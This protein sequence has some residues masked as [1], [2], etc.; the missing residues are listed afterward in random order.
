MSTPAFLWYATKRICRSFKNL[1]RKFRDYLVSL[2]KDWEYESKVY[3]ACNDPVSYYSHDYF[4][5]E[6]GGAEC[7]DS[8][9]FPLKFH[10]AASLFSNLQG[11]RILDYGS[12]R[13]ELTALLTSQGANVLGADI[14][15]AA[16]EIAKKLFPQAQFKVIKPYEVPHGPFDYIFL[17]DVIEHI[18]TDR[19]KPLLA[20][21]VEQLA[22]DGKLCVHTN[23]AD[24]DDTPEIRKFHPEHVTLLTGH[25]LAQ[26]LTDA[27][28]TVEL[29]LKRHR[30]EEGYIGGIWCIAK[31]SNRE[32]RT[33]PRTLF[34][35]E[36][37]LGDQL[38]LT[39]VIA[40]YRRKHPD[41]YI[42]VK[43]TH[44]EIYINN[45]H[46]DEIIWTKSK[47]HFDII[48]TIQLPIAPQLRNMTLQDASAI[49]A[50]LQLPED[51][52]RPQI[53][54]SD[55]ERHIWR[56]RFK[57]PNA[58]LVAFA[59]YS[60]WKS[61]EWPIS[62]WRVV[63]EWLQREYGAS[64]IYVGK[65]DRPYPWIGHNLAG[66]TDLRELALL[67]EQCDLL[68]SVDNG[69]T[70]LA[71]AV[72]TPT[73]A[74][75][76]PLLARYRITVPWIFPVQAK[77][78]VGCYHSDKWT[79]PPRICPLRHHKC[80]RDITTSDVMEVCSTVLRN[81]EKIK[82]KFQLQ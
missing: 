52:K 44:P 32:K 79:V 53:F 34:K 1:P 50:D 72:G 63:V 45:P 54:L 70:H 58:L 78:C 2:Y 42:A 28:L 57:R 64:I 16:I 80:M 68:L 20:S 65:G 67:L 31:K 82:S 77:E 73:V 10:F 22:S 18:R 5:K 49:Q 75:Y 59:P 12:G 43:V 69:V 35:Y 9:E 3:L 81:L 71:A 36:A 61:K 51:A 17:L 19:I 29:L 14:S 30:E 46:V 41:A 24:Q 13:G 21:L 27:G 38:C 6:S 26:L 37:T 23:D 76:G 47:A 74:L 25:E 8:G 15:S 48:N 66:L 40:E 4:L 11:K 33:G 7:I 56:N 62:R 60:G 39:P 55:L